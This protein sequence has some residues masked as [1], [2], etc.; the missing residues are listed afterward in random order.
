MFFPR[1][2]VS[3]SPIDL[4]SFFNRIDK[5]GVELIDPNTLTDR[6]RERG[7]ERDELLLLL[8]G[9]NRW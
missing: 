4:G 7:R 8:K 5:H 9:H 3:L 6:E 2:D 1:R